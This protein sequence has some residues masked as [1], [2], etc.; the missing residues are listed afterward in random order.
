M[1]VSPRMDGG[2]FMNRRPNLEE[3]VEM[4]A[5]FSRSGFTGFEGFF[6]FL[7]CQRGGKILTAVFIKFK[8]VMVKL[9]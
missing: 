2:M 1:S 5:K 7:T 4:A 9:K 8:I 3:L 6:Q